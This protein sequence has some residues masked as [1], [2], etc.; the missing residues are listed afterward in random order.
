MLAGAVLASNIAPDATRAET[1][2]E[3]RALAAELPAAA[4]VA[5]PPIRGLADR[6][7]PTPGAKDG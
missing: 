1:E 5:A 3:F 4:I 2:R 6:A 7:A